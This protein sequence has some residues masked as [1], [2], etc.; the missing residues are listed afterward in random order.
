MALTHN[1]QF[2]ADLVARIGEMRNRKLEQL[3]IGGGITDFAAYREQVGYLRA[4]DEV[5]VAC[6]EVQAQLNKR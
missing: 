4:L 3:G 5:Q 1:M 2:G 6:D